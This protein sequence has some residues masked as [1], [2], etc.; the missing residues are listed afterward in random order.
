MDSGLPATAADPL[1]SHELAPKTTEDRD[2]VKDGAEP[3]G[4]LA[5]AA[6]TQLLVDGLG[7][8]AVRRSSNG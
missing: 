1:S 4:R 7:D 6:A 3:P 5:S 8:D 2:P